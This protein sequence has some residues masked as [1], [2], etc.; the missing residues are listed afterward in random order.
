MPVVLADQ[1]KHLK[2]RRWPLWVATL[3]LLTLV[4]AVMALPFIRPLIVSTGGWALMI[5]TARSET[6]AN[7]GIYY[8][9]LGRPDGD[10]LTLRGLSIRIGDRSYEACV[11]SGPPAEIEARLL[12]DSGLV[13]R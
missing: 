7:S 1:P 8:F 10:Q 2:H 9:H 11:Y 13:V 4:I 12:E 6:A 5:S 3:L